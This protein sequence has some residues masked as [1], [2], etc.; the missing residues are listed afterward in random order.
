MAP[1]VEL[2]A[3]QAAIKDAF[4][5]DVGYWLDAFDHL[6]ALDPEFF[7]VFGEWL[8]H[9]YESDAL[10]AKTKEF[11]LI[12]VYANA[13]HLDDAGIRRH[14]RRAFEEGASVEEVL[15]VLQTSS[16]LGM[17][18]YMIGG[19][20]L[21]EEVEEVRIAD[22]R[23]EAL[24]DTFEER[25]G[26]RPEGWVPYVSPDPEF[27]EKYVDYSAHPWTTGTLDPEVREFVYIANDAAPA[28][29]LEEG[30]RGHLQAVRDNY[31]ATPAEIA[32]VLQLV[33]LLAVDT[34]AHGVPILVEEA[35]R[36]GVLG[37][38]GT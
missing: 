17:H 14:V 38:A 7:E 24:L 19:Q 10:D 28:H 23:V 1:D 6:L 8:A 26:F 34:I 27:F 11:V 3:E 32:C 12:A 20:V 22:E 9:P 36:A 37:D 21:Y 15:E 18:S 31:D 25:R 30:I 2:T 5:D 29:L 13:T 35:E 33:S 4:R 16:V